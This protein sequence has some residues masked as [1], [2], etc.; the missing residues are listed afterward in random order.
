MLVSL[1]LLVELLALPIIVHPEE[2]DIIVEDLVADIVVKMFF[3]VEL[4]ILT[5]VIL[6]VVVIPELFAEQY[7]CLLQQEFQASKASRWP[8]KGIKTQPLIL[9]QEL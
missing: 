8:L 9:L 1:S 6:T 3:N 4:L 5:L 7:A 2:L